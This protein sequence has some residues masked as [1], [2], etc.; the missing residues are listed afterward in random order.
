VTKT[1][2]GIDGASVKQGFT[3]HFLESADLV[4]KM[5]DQADEV[6]V[7]SDSSKFGKSGF[8]RILPFYGVD[9]LITDAQLN[10][11]FEKILTHADV[12]VVKT[13]MK[14]QTA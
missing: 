11:E 10:P 14:K 3:A 1:F 13:G 6:I 9:T 4:R 2:I 8:V 7:V 5:A 12:Q